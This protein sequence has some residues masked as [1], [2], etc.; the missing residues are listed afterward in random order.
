MGYITG[1]GLTCLWAQFN[2]RNQKLRILFYYYI[3]YK[4]TYKN[5]YIRIL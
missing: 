3:I 2:L 5:T 1:M 4:N